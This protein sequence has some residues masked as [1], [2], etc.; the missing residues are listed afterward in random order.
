MVCKLGTG[1]PVV[2]LQDSG[3]YLDVVEELV[4]GSK[5]KIW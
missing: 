5:P 4:A 2:T 1:R 3:R